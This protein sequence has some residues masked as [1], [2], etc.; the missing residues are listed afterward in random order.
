MLEGEDGVR[1]RIGQYDSVLLLTNELF[2]LKGQQSVHSPHFHLFH[3]PP[4]FSATSQNTS[5]TTDS[6]PA[7]RPLSAHPAARCRPPR[8]KALRKAAERSPAGRHHRRSHRC[9]VTNHLQ[10][11]FVDVFQP[12]KMSVDVIG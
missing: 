1:F 12:N 5:S 7:H 2:Q 6:L 3:F 8:W 4:R 10:S 9:V 11:V